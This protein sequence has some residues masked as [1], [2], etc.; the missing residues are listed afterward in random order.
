[1]LYLNMKLRLEESK[2]SVRLSKEEKEIFFTSN[3][4]QQEINIG[5]NNHFSY[6]IITDKHCEQSIMDFKA[7][8]FNILLPQSKVQNWKNSGSVGIH[9][10]FITDYGT[11]ISLFVEEDLKPKRHKK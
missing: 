7:F 1:M 11:E 9:E 4:L 5:T 8:S 2:I 3:S 6:S 10:T